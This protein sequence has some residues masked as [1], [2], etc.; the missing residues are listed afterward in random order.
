MKNIKHLLI[1]ILIIGIAGCTSM[2]PQSNA[3]VNKI[4]PLETRVKTL[5]SIEQWNLKGVIGIHNKAKP[6][7]DITASI[8]WQQNHAHYT[9]LLFGP[10][11]AN[12]TKL[13]GHPGSVK[14]QTSDGKTFTASSPEELLQK[15]TNWR[16]P[17]SDLYYWIR[18]LPAPHSKADK[19]YDA[20]QHLISL[21]QDGWNVS[22]AGY[23]S[24]RGVDVPNKMI[25][26][27]P[28]FNVKIIIKQW[29]F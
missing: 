24:Y 2:R 3:P 16:L 23:T 9:M 20:Y 15:Q 11:G 17:V 4:Q 27:N 19:Q 18:S 12:L 14:L 28:T 22:Y 5:S 7:D 29:N 26:V 13:S 8:Q 1:G 10:M 6:S 25:L 21:R